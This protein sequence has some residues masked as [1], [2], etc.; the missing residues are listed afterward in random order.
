MAYA[1]SDGYYCVGRG[2]LAYQ[3]G[4]AAPPIAPHHLYVVRFGGT[5]GIEAPVA[6]DL[7]QFQVQGIICADRAIRILAYDAI[8]TV[9][10]DATDRPVGFSTVPWTDHQ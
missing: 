6:L 4:F 8:Y 5:A 7:P 3:L 1:D 2:Y 9:R 10:L